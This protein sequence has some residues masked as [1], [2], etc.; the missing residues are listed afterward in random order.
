MYQALLTPPSRARARRAPAPRGCRGCAARRWRRSC[1]RTPGCTRGRRRL[2]LR[3]SSPTCWTARHTTRPRCTCCASARRACPGTSWRAAPAAP[4]PRPAAPS[5]R[6]LCPSCR[7]EGEATLLQGARRST[8]GLALLVCGRCC[9]QVPAAQ[10]LEGCVHSSGVPGEARLARVAA[11]HV[12][13]IATQLPDTRSR[14]KLY[15]WGTRRWQR[16]ARRARDAARS[17][18][19]RARAGRCRRGCCARARCARATRWRT[20]RATRSS[21]PSLLSRRGALGGPAVACRLLLTACAPG[22]TRDA[23]QLSVDA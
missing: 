1:A 12:C 21:S 7:R 14:A 15:A 20:T 19:A 6:L 17:W 22:T 9:A 5:L 13:G 2:A 4:A 16:S 18:R 3:T 11:L 23:S 8:Q 10:A